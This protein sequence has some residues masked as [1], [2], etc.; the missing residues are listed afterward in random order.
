M[1]LIFRFQASLGGLPSVCQELSMREFT[2]CGLNFRKNR[3]KLEIIPLI[4]F[5]G[6]FQERQ[7]LNMTSIANTV[8]ARGG[9]ISNGIRLL[10][11]CF[12]TTSTLC[13]S[14]QFSCLYYSTVLSLPFWSGQ[15]PKEVQAG[16][17][18][19]SPADWIP[20]TGFLC[21]PSTTVLPCPSSLSGGTQQFLK[22]YRTP[23]L[24]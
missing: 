22:T 19:D 1:K 7:C 4:T 24:L 20:A 12:F 3:S 14:S 10:Q 5:P 17:R 8:N 16:G 18:L 21:V 2:S 23:L 13:D 6:N 15:G 11:F 9:Y